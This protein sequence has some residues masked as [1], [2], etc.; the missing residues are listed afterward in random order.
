M[1]LLIWRYAIIIYSIQFIESTID[2]IYKITS[3]KLKI[4]SLFKTSVKSGDTVTLNVLK[5]LAEG[6]W[7][8]SIK[9][10]VIPARSEVDLLPGQKLKAQI[11]RSGDRLI[12][13]V[14]HDDTRPVRQLLSKLGV[15]QDSIS[16]SIVSA[17][18]K[19][20]LRVTQENIVTIRK[21]MKRINKEDPKM[22]RMLAILIGK[23]IDISGSGIDELLRLLDYGSSHGNKDHEKKREEEPETDEDKK[24]WLKKITRKT[25][26]NPDSL[27]QVFNNLNG[28]NNNW[29]VIPFAFQDHDE[30]YEGTIRVLF[31]PDTRKT[32]KLVLCITLPDDERFSF[33]MQPGADGVSV[34]M[35][36]PDSRRSA[37]LEKK[38][39]ELRIKLQN[40]GAKFDDIVYNEEEFDG[41]TPSTDVF[42]YKTIDT[43]T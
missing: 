17:L 11:L 24:K 12:L 32:E 26:G 16:E 1:E 8:V 4:D 27:L 6:K 19:S 7:A 18:V 42:P 13:K 34:R 40:K 15:P 22:S 39:H 43:L 9:G 35:F 3:D 29:I 28:K 23:N 33:F 37:H 31:N 10:K 20:D 21:M 14:L 41:F 2:M 38:L 30:V 5:Q 36:A 25:T